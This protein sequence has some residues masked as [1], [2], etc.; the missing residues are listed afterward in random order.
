MT[1]KKR[2]RGEVREERKEE[3]EEGERARGEARQ[4]DV[5]KSKQMCDKPTNNA[6]VSKE[7]SQ[8]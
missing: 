3:N 6:K 1:K 8:K 2:E 5:C 7:T 4:L